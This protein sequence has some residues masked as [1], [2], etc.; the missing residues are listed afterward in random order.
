M[1]TVVL[2]RPRPQIAR[3]AKRSVIGAGRVAY[4]NG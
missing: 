4:R 3:L 1:T 2:L